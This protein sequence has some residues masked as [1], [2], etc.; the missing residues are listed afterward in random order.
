MRKLFRDIGLLPTH[1]VVLCSAV[2]F[3]GQHV[4]QTMPKTR[5][6]LEKGFGNV[7]IIRDIHRLAKGGYSSEAL[8]EL[9]SF[10]QAY[11]GRMAIVLTRPSEPVD[12]LLAERHE[13]GTMFPDRITFQDLSPQDCLNLLDRLIHAEE[14]TAETPF[15]TSQAA[16]QRFQKAM[17]I[18]AMFEGWGNY[19]HVKLLET[20]MIQK[21]DDEIFLASR[22]DPEANTAGSSPKGW[23]CHVS[24]PY[25]TRSATRGLQ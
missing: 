24:R 22:R 3:I 23:L 1:Q 14:P 4:G 19:S 13:L 18:L 16:A 17:S 20:R 21:G 6:Q 10:V 12:E 11:S 25:S 15:F 7:L 8:D 5:M 9:T 2:N